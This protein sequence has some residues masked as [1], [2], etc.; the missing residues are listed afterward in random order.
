MHI[1][2]RDN[3]T[4]S[5]PRAANTVTQEA[6]ILQ[7]GERVSRQNVSENPWHGVSSNSWAAIDG[8]GRFDGLALPRRTRPSSESILASNTP[9]VSSSSSWR[10]WLSEGA[11]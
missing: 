5:R 7:E 2:R 10:P 4:E 6:D 1:V 9:S 8:V 11:S 3:E